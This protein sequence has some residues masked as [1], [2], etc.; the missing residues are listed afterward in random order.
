V[1]AKACL[2]EITPDE[3]I[4]WFDRYLPPTLDLG[5]PGARDAVMHAIQVCVPHATLLPIGIERLAPDPAETT[6]PRFVR[7]RERSREGDTFVYDVDVADAG[8]CVHERWQGLQLRL[9]SGTALGGPW[10]APLLGP[11]LERRLQELLPG[12]AVTVAVE[13][14]PDA[15]RR[16]RSDLAIQ[17]ALGEAVPIRRRPDG[18]PEVADGRAVSAAH[19]ADLTLAVAGPGPIGCDVEP[20]VA[21]PAGV[22]QDLLG[23]ERFGLADVMAREAG[24]AL[25]VAATRVWAASEC[26]RKAGA[27]MNAPLV[28]AAAHA[29][30]W[31]WLSAGA[32]IVVTF[33]AEV[34]AVRNRLVLA[35]LVRRGDAST[36]P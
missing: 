5:D 9:V 3:G 17:R 10:P 27:A 2:A 33:V 20:V 24:E 8:G 25:D 19:A 34:L 16:A 29:D 22:W 26:L 14:D 23:A 4:A 6:G 13:R 21:R 31:V 7:A 32:L 36:H 12:A 28:L 1:A 15:D 11:Y 30:G 35:V 18:K